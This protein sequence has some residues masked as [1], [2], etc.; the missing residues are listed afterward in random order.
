[1]LPDQGGNPDVV[2][3]YSARR[4]NTPLFAILMKKEIPMKAL[5]IVDV[6]KDFC[7]G[8]AL[9][10][11]DGDKIVPAINS[12]MDDFDIVVASRDDHPQCSKHFESWPAHCVRGT[13]G[14]EFHDELNVSRID[15]V[16]TKG[17]GAEDDGYSAFDA[18]NLDLEAYLRSKNVQNQLTVKCKKLIQLLTC[19]FLVR[20]IWLSFPCP[21]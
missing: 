6:Q 16:F 19:L 4:T 10:V 15:Q 21:Y 11:G 17:T 13:E 3:R 18:T 9:A 14:A 1:M 7:P 8:G 20:L 2:C 5:L 12:I